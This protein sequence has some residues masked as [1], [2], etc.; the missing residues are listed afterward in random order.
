MPRVYSAFDLAVSSSSWGE[1]FPNVV[2][3]AM[4]SGVP[5]IV[6]DVG[7]SASIVATTGWVCPP[8]DPIRLART[9]E[10]ALSSREEM[11]AR[12]RE[13]RRRIVAEF[14]TAQL[15]DTTL[16]LLGALVIPHTAGDNI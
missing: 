3:E 16:R 10:Q 13:A 8:G 11:T 2:A 1:G 4:A 14:S 15:T 6:T 5:C 12:G 7:D 9:L